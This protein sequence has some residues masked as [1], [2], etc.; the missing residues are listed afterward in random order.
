MNRETEHDETT[1]ATPHRLEAR[2][3]RLLGLLP[4]WYRAEREQEMVEVFL[5]DRAARGRD[6]GEL[7][8]EYGWPGWG[9]AAAVAGLAIRVR[10]GGPGDPPGPRATGAVVRAAATGAVLLSAGAA[11][12]TAIWWVVAALVGPVEAADN[13]AAL[14]R[15]TGARQWHDAVVLVLGLCW[16]PAWTAFTAGRVQPA[17]VLGVLATVAPATAVGTALVDT[18]VTA[19]TVALAAVLMPGGALVLLRLGFHR[20]AP[21]P[22]VA[23]PWTLLAA[24]TVGLLVAAVLVLVTRATFHPAATL[25]LVAA[26]GLLATRRA[27]A[28]GATAVL[29]AITLVAGLL[30]LAALEVG[31]A[32]PLVTVAL[33]AVTLLVAAVVARRGDRPT[34][35]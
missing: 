33:G 18:S 27:R 4:A 35:G 19:A 14:V 7:D 9:E 13:L 12:A 1:A 32:G 21:P 16:L 24:T 23:R 6:T 11:A 10:I 5:D 28:A 17:R 8:A 22:A 31:R 2:Y 3:R 30:E 26:L 15:P 25:L 20:D 34:P 29:A